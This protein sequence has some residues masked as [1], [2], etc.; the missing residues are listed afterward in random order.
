MSFLHSSPFQ[1]TPARPVMLPGVGLHSGEP[2]NVRILPA[3]VNHGLVFLREDLPG[4][5]RI[6]ARTAFVTDTTLSTTLGRGHATIRTVEHLLAAL[7][8]LGITNAL[9][10]VDGPEVPALDGSAMP[11]VR[12]LEA[13]GLTRQEAP[14]RML[15][16]CESVAVVRDD[17][18]VA[19]EPAD[20]PWIRY[21]VDYGHPLAGPQ[22]LRVSVE[23][24]VLVREILDART[25]C[26]EVEAERM[27]AL[28]LARGGSVENAVVVHDHGT[29]TPLRH[30]DEFVRHKILDLVGDLALTGCRW[31]GAVSATRAG[32][33][34]HVALAE[35][36]E[37][38]VGDG[39]ETVAIGIPEAAEVSRVP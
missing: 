36:L 37:S 22:A 20:A 7:Y 9:L 13:V 11:V 6:P 18:R 23:S 34:L 16:V 27:R 31:V 15:R 28:G 12:A 2:V 39:D 10:A 14:A 33:A 30:A 21:Q 32:H 29:S 26:L 4:R 38:M 5:P 24:D 19:A 8:A 1:A 35:R 3:P 25:F 17:R